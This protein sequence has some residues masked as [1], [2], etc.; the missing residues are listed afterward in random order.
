MRLKR[1]NIHYNM[2][3]VDAYNKDFNIIISPREPGKST[4]TW[5]KAYKMFKHRHRPTI[6]LRRQIADITE[7][8]VTSI[9]DT[10]NQFL[11]ADKQIDIKFKKGAIKDGVVDLYINDKVFTRIV[12]LSNPKSRIKSLILDDPYMMIFD[13][14]IVDLRGGEK[15][16]TDEI[17]KFLDCYNTFYRHATK[18]NHKMKCYFLGNPYTI[19][20]PYT[21]WLGVDLNLIKPGA[22]IVGSNYIIDC[23]QLTEELKEFILSHNPTYEFDDTYTRYAFGGEAVNDINYTIVK[24]QPDGYSLKYIFKIANKY[25]GIYHMNYDRKSIGYNPGKFWVTIL[26][27]YQGSKKVLAVDFNNL[28]AGTQLITPDIRAICIRFK[29]AIALRDISYN[30]IEC[31][32]LIEDIY[33]LI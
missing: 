1:D 14:F 17:N 26:K 22:F 5:Y 16:L 11:D 15:Y 24:R 7:A 18:H 9:Q 33:K 28:V 30:S 12:A 10:I 29:D 27:D 21:V 2:R 23:Y 20:S 25:L 3:H 31:G 32:Y 6:A 13:E 4:S 19:Y 8:Y